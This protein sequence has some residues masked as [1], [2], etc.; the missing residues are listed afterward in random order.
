MINGNRIIRTFAGIIITN[1]RL[2]ILNKH[3]KWEVNDISN[4]KDEYTLGLF[5]ID[6]N[7]YIFNGLASMKYNNNNSIFEINPEEN[8][9]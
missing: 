2:S 4:K 3:I 5:S 1:K 7:K 6:R 9:I 8:N